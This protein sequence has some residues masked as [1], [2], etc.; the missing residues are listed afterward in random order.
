MR[1]FARRGIAP[2]VPT[3][4]CVLAVLSLAAARPTLTGPVETLWEV[5]PAGDTQ[6]YVTLTNDYL[7]I[8]ADGPW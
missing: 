3:V 6:G 8:G 1:L 7:E 4:V 2:S 5:P